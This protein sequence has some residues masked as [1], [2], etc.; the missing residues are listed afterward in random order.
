MKKKKNMVEM[1]IEPIKPDA[2]QLNPQR[3]FAEMDVVNLIAFIDCRIPN[4]LLGM[5]KRM[6]KWETTIL[7]LDSILIIES[8]KS[9]KSARWFSSCF[10]K[11][12]CHVVPLA[13]HKL[14]HFHFQ[15]M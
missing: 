5:K 15:S 9:T 10:I 13:L 4:D 14:N 2:K 6:K 11:H 7:I 8:S 3:I 12:F 1:C